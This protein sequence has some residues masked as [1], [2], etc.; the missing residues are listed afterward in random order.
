MTKKT[1]EEK[2][3]DLIQAI[4]KGLILEGIQAFQGKV[5]CNSIM[6]PLPKGYHVT[7]VEIKD[8]RVHFP[9]CYHQGTLVVSWSGIAK[10]YSEKRVQLIIAI[11][12]A[13]YERMQKAY[14]A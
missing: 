12:K 4:I 2:D 6:A 1:K 14:Q 11:A 10:T 8:R 5:F 9:A 13:R 7:L 3:S